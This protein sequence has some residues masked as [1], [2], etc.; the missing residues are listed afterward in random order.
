MVARGA[1][2]A[3]SDGEV[4]GL[5]FHREVHR[6]END[7]SKPNAERRITCK[8]R[9]QAPLADGCARSGCLR[10]TRLRALLPAPAPG[11]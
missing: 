5:D 7:T 6:I 9:T 2:V 3:I 1:Q 10:V 11:R 8:V 4:I